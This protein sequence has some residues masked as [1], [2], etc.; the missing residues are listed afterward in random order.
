MEVVEELQW[1]LLIMEV[2]A[3]VLMNK[4]GIVILKVETEVIAALVAA[5]VTRTAD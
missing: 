3:V 4:E 2:E 1:G 5:V